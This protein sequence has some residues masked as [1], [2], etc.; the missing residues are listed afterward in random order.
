MQYPPTESRTYISAE[1]HLVYEGP[2]CQRCGQTDMDGAETISNLTTFWRG[3]LNGVQNP[4]L[5]RACIEDIRTFAE[6]R[7]TRAPTS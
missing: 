5:C 1:G 6:L 3:G 2:P 4:T 7:I